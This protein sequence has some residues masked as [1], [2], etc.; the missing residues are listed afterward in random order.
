MFP[1]GAWRSAFDAKAVAATVPKTLPVCRKLK[2]DPKLLA[3]CD[4]KLQSPS[5]R[6]V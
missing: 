2:V 6:Y 5:R 3:W 4:R 1:F